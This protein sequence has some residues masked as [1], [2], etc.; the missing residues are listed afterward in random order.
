[1][2]RRISSSLMV[3][4]LSRL[5]WWRCRDRPPR[6]RPWFRSRRAGAQP[7]LTFRVEANFV[8]VDAFVSDTAATRLRICA[9]P[10]FQLFEDGKAAAW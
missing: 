2:F 5:L 10:D 8:E 6:A 1:M 9:P 3:A 7:P 4:A